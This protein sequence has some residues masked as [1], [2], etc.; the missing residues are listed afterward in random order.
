MI[1]I[2]SIIYL[3]NKHQYH[4]QNDFYKNVFIFMDNLYNI[5]IL[6]LDNF[7]NIYDNVNVMIFLNVHEMYQYHKILFYKINNMDDIIL[8]NVIDYINL[9][10]YVMLIM[11][12]CINIV[13]IINIYDFINIHHLK[14][15]YNLPELST[16][17]LI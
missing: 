17:Y 2:H 8:I 12:H 14:Y 7:V 5:H 1:Q 3:L 10:S 6:I 16:M 11:L 4:I 9:F 13:Q 15:L